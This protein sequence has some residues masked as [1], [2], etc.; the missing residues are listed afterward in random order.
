MAGPPPFPPPP[1]SPGTVSNPYGAGLD[2]SGLAV[3]I[4]KTRAV[5]D[6]RYQ[7]SRYG[8]ALEID[9]GSVAKVILKQTDPWV[10]FQPTP[11]TWVRAH[12]IMTV[13]MAE[14]KQPQSDESPGKTAEG[15]V[16]IQTA[17]TVTSS[18]SVRVRLIQQSPTAN[19][20]LVEAARKFAR[21]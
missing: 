7:N 15:T 9:D 10:D 13:S 18:G 5:R 3:L 19:P 2:S 16:R 11:W 17:G 8:V 14:E 12:A 4:L 6:L 21:G 20:K 1:Y